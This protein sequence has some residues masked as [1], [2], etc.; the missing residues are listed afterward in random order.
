MIIKL[1]NENFYVD[2][3]KDGNYTLYETKTTQSGKNA[4][5][6]YDTP[7]GYYNTLSSAVKRYISRQLGESE[8]TI[9]IEQFLKIYE[10]LVNEVT[11]YLMPKEVN[12]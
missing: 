11:Q 5:T 9:T 6:K 10:R 12:V 1:P 8:D 7:I 2:F 4:G 3:D